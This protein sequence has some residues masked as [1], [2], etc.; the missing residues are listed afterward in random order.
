MRKSEAYEF[1][2]EEYKE[3]FGN[4]IV[5]PEIES[6]EFEFEG[7]LLSERNALTVSFDVED[8]EVNVSISKGTNFEKI[9][10]TEFNIGEASEDDYM[11][12]YE[13][14]EELFEVIED[15]M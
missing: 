1:F 5:A 6:E 12:L 2:V 15:L 9:K 4:S 11:D 13:D 10:G 14:N 3:Q 8:V 7:T